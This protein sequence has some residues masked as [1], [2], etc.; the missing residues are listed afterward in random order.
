[1]YLELNYI[2]QI[3]YIFIQVICLPFY[4]IYIFFNQFIYNNFYFHKIY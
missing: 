4:Y 1:M 3:N 2:N